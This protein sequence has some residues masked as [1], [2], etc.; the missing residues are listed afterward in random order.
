MRDLVKYSVEGH[1]KIYNKTTKSVVLD[2]H[3]DI[4]YGNM[5]MALGHSLIGN[6][7]NF[8]SYIA[9][10]DGAAYIDGTGN[11][12]YK[13]SLGGVDSAAKNPTANLYNTLFVKKLGNDYTGSIGSG[14]S[15]AN[16]PPEDYA[17]P[18]EDIV[19]D[20][21]LDYDEPSNTT[22]SMIFNELGLFAGSVG[23]DA[24]FPGD[25]TTSTTEVE[26]FI[27][28]LPNFSTAPSVKSKIMLTHAIFTPIEKT[29]TDAYQITYTLRVQI[30]LA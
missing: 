11:I 4:L 7:K 12:V 16:T 10:G 13:V 29:S 20:M 28:Q 9:F 18:Y 21:T 17:V 5:S 25:S 26:D 22:G 6:T 2:T 3:N 19:V 30:Y 14:N 24:L 1:I 23:D 15:D 8:L 27:F